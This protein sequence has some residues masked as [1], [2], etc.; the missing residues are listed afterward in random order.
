VGGTWIER[1]DVTANG[2]SAER[3]RLRVLSAAAS[4]S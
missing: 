2:P 3:G 4:G 1:V